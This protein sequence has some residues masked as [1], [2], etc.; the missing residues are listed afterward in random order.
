[1]AQYDNRNL[2]LPTSQGGP[3]PEEK[4][5]FLARRDV[6]ETP[7]LFKG[8]D[9]VEWRGLG[10][11]TEHA[12]TNESQRAASAGS[13]RGPW[14]GRS[15]WARDNAV[16]SAKLLLGDTVDVDGILRANRLAQALKQADAMIN[17]IK[18]QPVTSDER[19]PKNRKPA[20]PDGI[21]PD[22]WHVSHGSSNGRPSAH[23]SE[24]EA[25]RRHAK[26]PGRT[27]SRA[28]W[29]PTGRLE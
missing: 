22:R 19:V 8:R 1:M 2:A 25:H 7:H 14:D 16:R 26:N 6:D 29:R 12:G 9:L 10:E 4:P 13:T 11:V 27:A 3:S 20:I 5:T 18:R 24:S 28:H 15:A 23:L 21:R 17:G